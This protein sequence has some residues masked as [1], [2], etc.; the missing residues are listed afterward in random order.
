M[1]TGFLAERIGFREV[2]A[3]PLDQVVDRVSAGEVIVLRRCLQELG[4]FGSFHSIIRQVLETYIGAERTE[5]LMSQG[6]QWLHL[7]LNSK[8]LTEIAKRLQPDFGTICLMMVKRVARD[9][10]G[11]QGEAYAEESRNLRIFVPQDSWVTGQADYL[12]F[13]RE[14]SRGKLT[15]H[16]PHTDLWGYH[17]L[18]VINVWTAI[19]PVAPRQ[20]YEYLAGSFWP[21]S[22][23]G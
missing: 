14:R 20:W 10:L 22:S 15:L 8:E 3:V 21:H 1:S 6:V 11:V 19:S 4:Y 2:A 5:A 18:N 23:N 16:G 13:E 9:L 17:P 12:E 7:F